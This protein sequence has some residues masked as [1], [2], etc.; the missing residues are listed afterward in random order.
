[1]NKQDIYIKESLK[2]FLKYGIKSVTIGQITSR[3]NVSSKTIYNLFQDKTGLVQACF[4]LYKVNSHKEFDALQ[5]QAD[6]VADLVIRFYVKLVESLSLINPNFFNDIAH[7]FPQIWDTNEAFGI[8]HT[9]EI[10]QQGID[11]GIFVEGIDI[12]ICATTFTMLVQS[13]FENDE[14]WGKGTQKLLTNVLW[15]YVRGICT[16]EGLEEFRKYRRFMLV[17][18]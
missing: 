7:Y 5:K 16:Q 6:N 18:R 10:I 8:S 17:A 15:P 1:M 14:L 3:L 12:D 9:R 13:M 4:E 2:L 11:E